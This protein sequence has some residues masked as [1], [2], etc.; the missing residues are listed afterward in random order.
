MTYF[1]GN[2]SYRKGV[3]KLP[4]HPT[5]TKSSDY[6]A[7]FV[8]ELFLSVEMSQTEFGCWRPPSWTHYFQ[9]KSKMVLAYQFRDKVEISIYFPSVII[10]IQNCAVRSAAP[11]VMDSWFINYII[12]CKQCV[13]LTHYVFT[14][15]LE[16]QLFIVCLYF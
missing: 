4:P 10:A 6:L 9:N 3:R 7:I 8:K 16:Y 5:R 1:Y 14:I 13:K 2:Q 11:C 12:L 15:Q